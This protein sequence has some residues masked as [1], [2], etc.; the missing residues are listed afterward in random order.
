MA[1]RK[2]PDYGSYLTKLRYSN[3]YYNFSQNIAALYD[4]YNNV[5]NDINNNTNIV[6]N[7]N[8]Y[9]SYRLDRAKIGVKSFNTFIVKPIDS[10]A[11]NIH[12]VYELQSTI[13]IPDGFVKRIVNTCPISSEKTVSIYCVNFSGRGSLNNV[14]N[15][16]NTYIFACEGDCLELV[17]STINNY[18]CVQKYGGVFKNI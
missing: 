6:M 11:R 14:G 10:I 7:E 17:W 8:I 1:I 12:T 3:N 15:I 13:D 2:H 5:N 9:N 16:F 18:W 4:T